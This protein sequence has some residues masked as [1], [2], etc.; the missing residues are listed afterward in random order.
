LQQ[1]KNSLGTFLLTGLYIRYKNN[2]G[3]IMRITILIAI[4]LT[5]LFAQGQMDRSDRDE[6]KVRK[7]RMEQLKNQHQS[8]MIGIQTDYLNLSVEQ[9]EQFF[10]MQKKY[11]NEV[12]EVQKKFRKK[13]ASL[14]MKTKDAAKFDVDK[15]IKLQKEM[16]DQLAVL[17]ADFL[18]KT[19]NVLSNEQRTKLVFQ[20]ERLKS[21]MSKRA[22]DDRPEMSKKRNFERAKK[23]K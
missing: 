4:F 8:T 7:E 21:Q 1:G 23:R 5:S 10:P 3:V 14:R 18:R 20:Q 6:M 2:L 11:R 9:A 22:F 19:T 13:V 12:N 17:E 16:K 15:A